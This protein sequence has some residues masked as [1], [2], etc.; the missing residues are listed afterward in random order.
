[1]SVETA[2]LLRSTGRLYAMSDYRSSTFREGL[3]RY[4]RQARYGGASWT[5]ISVASTLSR[6]TVRRLT[7]V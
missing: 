4:V 5:D 6:R 7:K 2:M 3:R 1:M